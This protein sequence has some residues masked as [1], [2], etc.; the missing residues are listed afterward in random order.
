M[1]AVGC[2][3]TVAAVQ[4]APASS[5]SASCAVGS[6]RSLAFQGAAVVA[7]PLR[8]CRR[9]QDDGVEFLQSRMQR[10]SVKAS[11]E[12]AESEMVLNKP[13][14]SGK[15][16]KVAVAAPKKQRVLLRF[17]WLEKNIGIGLDQ[18]V[19]GHGTVPLSPYFFWPRKDAWEE[20]KAKLDSKGWISRKRTIILLNQATDIINL[21]QQNATDL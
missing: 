10:L 2:A 13:Q 11:A 18:V 19:P 21:W 3:G 14:G 20:L 17:L 4:W 1:A 12:A 8:V 16:K 5:A 7:K 6:S 9:R 15:K